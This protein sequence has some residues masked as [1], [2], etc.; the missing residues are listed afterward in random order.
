[1]QSIQGGDGGYQGSQS[2]QQLRSVVLSLDLVVTGHVSLTCVTSLP[3]QCFQSTKPVFSVHVR[4][5][6]WIILT[7]H[8]LL[9]A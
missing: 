6:E 4:S 1:M 8:V 7:G 2:V 5:S 3:C 9:T